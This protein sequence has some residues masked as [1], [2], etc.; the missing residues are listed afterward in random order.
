MQFEKMY[1]YMIWLFQWRD[2]SVEQC[3]AQKGILTL[4]ANRVTIQLQWMDTV[5]WRCK[6]LYSIP[7]FPYNP[8]AKVYPKGHLFMYDGSLL[9]V[10]QSIF[11]RA[12]MQA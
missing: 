1:T 4:F 6:L 10:K 7:L 12:Q 8:T 9:S 11:P 2:I 3:D 5:L